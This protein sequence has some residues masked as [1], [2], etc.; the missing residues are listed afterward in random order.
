MTED[1]VHITFVSQYF[2]PEVCAPANRTY[3][4]ARQW[5]EAGH[6][7]TVV[8]GFPNH[9]DGIIPE[10]Y[11]GEVIREETIDGI[12]VLRTWLYATPNAGV[13]RRVANFLSFATTSTVFGR[14]LTDRPDV[15][16]A[17]SPQFF[18][19]LAGLA[20]SRLFDVPY[21]LEI[22]DLW[23]ES[24]I[25]LGVL[26][27]PVTIGVLEGLETM[28]YRGADRI[29]IVSESFRDHIADRGVPSDDIELIPNGISPAFLEERREVDVDEIHDLDGDFLVGYVG[30]H[31]M[32]HGLDKVLDAAERLEGE[33]VDFLFVGDGARKDDLVAE[34]ERRELDNVEFV[35][36]QPRETIP[37]FYEACDVCLV[38]LRDKDVFKTV[39]PSKMFEI[40]ALG[41]PM[42]VSVG[43]EA[44]R[45]VEKGEAGVCVEPEN[46][47][48]MVREI[49]ELR[50]DKER[51]EEL[52]ERAE[53]YVWEEFSRPALAEKYLEVFEEVLG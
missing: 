46:V 24:A 1:D 45:V 42:L 25:E 27:D 22:R 41:R 12:E 39:L 18:V 31:G 43:G 13:V 2:P 4:H 40:M 14:L 6:D 20:L 44:Q 7:V 21:V 15:V 47:G 26:N 51:R 11:R 23:P 50:D 19:G 38:P 48:E 33:H 8:T 36:L 35:G 5:V 16:A 29:V 52:G 30:T 53:D 3:E 10:E 37:S 34:A 28:M 9:P 32:A 49:D 17:T